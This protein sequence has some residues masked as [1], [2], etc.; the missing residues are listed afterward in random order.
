MGCFE[1]IGPMFALRAL[2]MLLPGQGEVAGQG[3][4]TGLELV[5]V[6]ACHIHPPLTTVCKAQ[7]PG[8][9]LPLQPRPLRLSPC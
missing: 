1:S 3:A 7:G 4:R 6:H 9:P 2:N 5:S 8:V